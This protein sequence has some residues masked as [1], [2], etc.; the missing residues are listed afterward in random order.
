MLQSDITRSERAVGVCL[1]LPLKAGKAR[2]FAA[3]FTYN[4]L[5]DAATLFGAEQM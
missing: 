5:L 2:P 4:E 1:L 3:S